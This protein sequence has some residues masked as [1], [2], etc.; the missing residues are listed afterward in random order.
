MSMQISLK[1]YP[2]CSLLSF[3]TSSM[4]SS[5]L[6]AFVICRSGTIIFSIRLSEIMLNAVSSTMRTRLLFEKNLAMT[7]LS[8]SLGGSS[9]FWIC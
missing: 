8:V 9:S 4:H 7:S 5:P 6:K 3:S 1:F 2:S